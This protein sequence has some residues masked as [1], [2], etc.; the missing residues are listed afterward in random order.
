[1]TPDLTAASRRNASIASTSISPNSTRRRAPAVE[2]VRRVGGAVRARGEAVLV[3]AA[4]RDRRQSGRGGAERRRSAAAAMGLGRVRVV[5]RSRSSAQLRETVEVAQ[6]HE[7]AVA[8]PPV[9]PAGA[10]RGDPEHDGVASRQASRGGLADA[11]AVRSR[12]RRRRPWSTSST[13]IRRGGAAASARA[14]AIATATPLPLS[15]RRRADSAL[16]SSSSSASASTSA[17]VGR[18]WSSPIAGPSD[19][20]RG[21]GS[22]SASS[23]TSAIAIQPSQPGQS[24]PRR[25]SVAVARANGRRTSCAVDEA[26]PAGVVV[27]GDD[28]ADSEALRLASACGGALDRHDVLARALGGQPPAGREPEPLVDDH[29]Q[30]AARMSAPPIRGERPRE[31]ARQSQRDVP[32]VGER[33][34][35]PAPE[36]LDAD[37]A[38]AGGHELRRQPA[39]RAPFGVGAGAT[40]LERGERRRRSR[41]CPSARDDRKAP[42]AR[43]I[44]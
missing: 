30:Q 13:D 38:G 23:Q 12:R 19:R 25:P 3:K 2:R 34:V 24:G 14:S 33:P 5:A 17:T 36:G 29:R 31:A 10:G 20:R 42:V 18:N 7:R 35:R 6:R 41:R 37:V 15:D 22:R 9:G 8:Q 4:D 43:R 44:R 27:G 28:Q 40:A 16:A 26:R 1:M 32:G 11:C 21:G 39:R